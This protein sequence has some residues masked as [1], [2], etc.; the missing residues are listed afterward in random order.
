MR[1]TTVIQ[2]H[3]PLPQNP[4]VKG[5][6]KSRKLSADS[7][8]LNALSDR[9]INSR[10][11]LM[12]L[13]ST[14]RCDTQSVFPQSPPDQVFYLSMH[15]V[16]KE[17]N[18]TT[19]NRVVFDSSAKFSSG[20]SLNDTLLVGPTVHFPLLDVLIRFRFI[21]LP[22]LVTSAKCRDLHEFVW[23]RTGSLNT[24]YEEMCSTF[25]LHADLKISTRVTA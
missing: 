2:I 18:T 4:Q 23:S 15:A 25:S 19:K 24:A 7:S 5:I 6:G 12:W 16:C 17:H 20:I 14:L 8:H 21:A 9:G 10:N 1:K 3:V 13:K 11:S 22:S